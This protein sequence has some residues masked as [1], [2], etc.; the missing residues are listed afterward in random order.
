MLW[1]FKAQISFIATISK[2]QDVSEMPR[3]PKCR[4]VMDSNRISPHAAAQSPKA[5]NGH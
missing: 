2:I 5:L 1:V 4:D 3:Y